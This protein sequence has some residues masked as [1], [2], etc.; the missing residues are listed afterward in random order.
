[1]EPMSSTNPAPRGPTARGAQTDEA[2]RAQARRRVAAYF[3]S[4]GIDDPQRIDAAADAVLGRVTRQH[5]ELA[6]QALGFVAMNEARKTVREWLGA[7]V[8]RGDLPEPTVMTTGLIIWRLRQALHAYPDAFL[9]RGDLPEGFLTAVRNPAP[10]ML[11]ESL[12]GQMEPQRIQWRALRLP[13]GVMQRV[14]QLGNVTH[15]LVYSVVGGR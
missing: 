1:M 5:P 11:P 14:Q 4:L 9:R 12:P 10:A 13:P 15:D 6:A 3:R 8:A 7:L 2:T